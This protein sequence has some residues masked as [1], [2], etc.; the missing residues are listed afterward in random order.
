MWWNV[1]RALIFNLLAFTL[2]VIL[3]RYR[4]PAGVAY[5]ILL[6]FLLVVVY[7]PLRPSEAKAPYRA[8]EQ[9][10]W[11]GGFL[12]VLSIALGLSLWR[13]GDVDLLRVMA[14]CALGWAF[15]FLTIRDTC[16]AALKVSKGDG[17]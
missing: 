16:L 13:G 9:A 3:I 1:G 17:A 10:L 7:S 5:P 8:W 12:L 15:V 14:A 6:L 4:S 11:H 2:I